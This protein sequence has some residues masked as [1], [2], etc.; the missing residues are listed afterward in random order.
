L[1]GTVHKAKSARNALAAIRSCRKQ[2]PDG[3][4]IYVILDNLNSHRGK[5]L[6]AWCEDNNVELCFTPTYASWANPI[7]AHFAPAA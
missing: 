7:E 4:R 3:E 2:R 1:W 6:V 5:T